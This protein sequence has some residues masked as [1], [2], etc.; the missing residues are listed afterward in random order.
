MYFVIDHTIYFLVFESSL[1]DVV[2]FILWYHNRHYSVLLQGSLLFE[3]V[4]PHQIQF[5][6]SHGGKRYASQPFP[7]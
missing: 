7:S 4:D 2:L 5:A 3:G 6:K 1:K